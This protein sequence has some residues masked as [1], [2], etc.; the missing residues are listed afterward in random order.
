MESKN[1]CTAT[2]STSPAW[3]LSTGIGPSCSHCPGL[4]L[5]DIGR[6]MGQ[7]S[8]LSST[9]LRL[10]LAPPGT[11]SITARWALIGTLHSMLAWEPQAWK[12]S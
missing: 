5:A 2:L 3:R 4:A 1:S 12:D 10:T 8:G 7:E 6:S 9:I 11:C